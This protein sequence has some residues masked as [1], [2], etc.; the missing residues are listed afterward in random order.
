MSDTSANVPDEPASATAAPDAAKPIK[1]RRYRSGTAGWHMSRESVSI[2]ITDVAQWTEKECHDFLV[3]VRFGSLNNV[4]CPHCG[5]SLPE[6]GMANF[7]FNKPA[8]A[9]PTP[10]ERAS[11]TSRRRCR[12]RRRP[13]PSAS[14]LTLML[15]RLI[16]AFQFSCSSR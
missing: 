2:S 14:Q 8:G 7:S 15:A 3:E 6:I 16:T 5:A 10:R 1:H 4:R 13:G 11:R 12:T 9:C